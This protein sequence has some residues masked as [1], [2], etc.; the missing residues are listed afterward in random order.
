MFVLDYKD[1]RPI[2]KQI[3]SKFQ[4]LILMDILKTDEAMPSVRE[5]AMQ[6]S[7]NPNTIQR[8]YETL[9]REG[10]IYTIR[11]RGSFVA[12]GTDTLNKKKNELIIELE[13]VI[14]KAKL[15][16][17]DEKE[18]VKYVSDIYKKDERR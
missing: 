18:F 11:G 9:E 2:Y 3:V 7:I 16:N 8:A 12:A 5:L 14:N 1:R 10:W 15:L 6:L 4:E 13:T 17:V